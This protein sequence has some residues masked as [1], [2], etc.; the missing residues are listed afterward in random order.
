M[1]SIRHVLFAVAVILLATLPAHAQGGCVNS[2]EA[3]TAVL[4]LV[5]SAAA[6]VSVATKRMRQFRSRKQP[7]G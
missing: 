4:A 6:F 3:P 2:P 5:G 1:K 7:R